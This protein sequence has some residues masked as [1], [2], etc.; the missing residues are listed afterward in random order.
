MPI[1]IIKP[2]ARDHRALGLRNREEA[3]GVLG[4]KPATLAQWVYQRRGP[5]IVYLGRSPYYS[6]EAIAAFV[7]QCTVDPA[8]LNV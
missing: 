6:D 3:A 5:K 4:V 1:T 8:T 7:E 2:P